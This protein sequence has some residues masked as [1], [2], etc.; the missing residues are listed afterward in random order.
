MQ[1][2][3]TKEF[4]E[5][6]G[7][8]QA[9]LHSFERDFGLPEKQILTDFKE[10]GDTIRHRGK[11]LRIAFD[12]LVVRRRLLGL[13]NKPHPIRHLEVWIGRGYLQRLTIEPRAVAKMVDMDFGFTEL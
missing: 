3:F 1:R 6:L 13:T 10:S 7:V 11:V 4:E 2:R 12:F 5:R 9:K 8:R